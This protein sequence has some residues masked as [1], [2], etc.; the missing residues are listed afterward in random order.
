MD[1]FCQASHGSDHSFEI[2]KH[3]IK[4]KLQERTCNA[5]EK[6]SD[7]RLKAHEPGGMPGQNPSNWRASSNKWVHPPL[8]CIEYS[9]LIIKPKRGLCQP[10]PYQPSQTWR[11][12]SSLTGLLAPRRPK[13]KSKATTDIWKC[14][15]RLRS[16]QARQ[17]PKHQQAGWQPSTERVY[18]EHCQERRRRPSWS[19]C[20]RRQEHA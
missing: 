8:R 7:P 6:R 20:G 12:G 19:I 17:H 4:I 2:A 15:L 5:R 18:S 9:Q 3:R 10:K 1:V 11:K 13:C 16:K 14:I